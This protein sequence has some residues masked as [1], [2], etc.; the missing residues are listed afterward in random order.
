MKNFVSVIVT[1]KNEQEAVSNLLK[2]IKAQSYKK[3][4]IIVVDN[5]SFDKTLEIS[6]K[7]TPN[8]FMFGPERSSQRNFGVKKSKGEYVL[9]MDADMILTKD[10][11]KSCVEKIQTGK[12]I[13]ALV[14]PEKSYGEGFWSKCKA[15]E[16]EFYLGDENIEAARFFKKNIF[17]K[18]GGYDTKI[19]G[20]EDWDL[21][22]RMKKAGVKIGR[23]DN[24]ILHDEKK[25]SPIKSAR[26]KFYYG[27]HA[28]EYLKKHPEMILTQGNL[29]FR[30]S[31][32]KQ[33][34][35]MITNPLL[36]IGMISNRFLEMSGAILGIIV[37]MLKK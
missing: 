21:P 35:K 7:F 20:P 14:I 5:N 22:L 2:S 26:K 19:T 13:G 23:I 37:A 10:V 36:T 8:I 15:F 27:L 31:F 11:I 18:F 33:I 29:L 28:K 6:K 4:E 3:I 12:S 9:I 17:L 32:F 34:P 24:F 25:F 16:R 30:P 1:T